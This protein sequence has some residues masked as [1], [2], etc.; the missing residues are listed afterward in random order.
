MNG[1]SNPEIGCS[2]RGL[3]F[4]PIDE[5]TA[6]EIRDRIIETLR[7][8][9]PRIGTLLVDVSSDADGNSYDVK[10]EYGLNESNE[11]QTVTV[12]LERI[13]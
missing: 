13:R 7:K 3:L 11:R 4:D 5:I 1:C 10:V 2:L 6:L 9:E 8:H 12:I